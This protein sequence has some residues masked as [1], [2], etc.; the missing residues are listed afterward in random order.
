MDDWIAFWNSPHAIYVN[1][2]HRDVHYRRIAEDITR[3]EHAGGLVLDYG[4][5]E[6]LHADIPAQLANR[7][8]LCEA[9]STVRESLAKRF[10]DN[11][12]IEVVTPEQVEALPDKSLDLIVM[13]SVVQYI[14]EAELDR[15]LVL[16]HR[17]LKATGLFVLGD[18]IPTHVSAATDAVELLKF[19]RRE[20]FFVAA[21]F[22]LVRT[23]LS[24]YWIMRTRFGLTRYHKDDFL[25]KLTA[26]GYFATTAD[27]NIG[28]NQNRMTFNARTSLF[29]RP[30]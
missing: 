18:I 17:L 2:R 26:A 28:H 13:H 21:L 20:G 3:Y 8:Y 25:A 10:A 11:P 7:L 1:A 14:D 16:F 24:N 6:A 23:V 4:C 5:G 15:L 9:A 27:R 12:K 30:A 19:G 22:G 29:G